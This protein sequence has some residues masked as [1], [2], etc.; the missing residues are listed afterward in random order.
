M[1]KYIKLPALSLYFTFIFFSPAYAYLDP[2]T[3]NIILQ[4]IIAFIAGVGA[5]YRM[6]IFRIKNIFK[7]KKKK[8]DE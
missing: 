2:G 5:T 6:W 1:I 8:I 3:F 7:K 4:S